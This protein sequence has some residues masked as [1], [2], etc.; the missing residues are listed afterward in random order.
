[1]QAAKAKYKATDLDTPF[2][3]TPESQEPP[4]PKALES[5]RDLSLTQDQE[6]IRL[7][8]PYPMKE[9]CFKANMTI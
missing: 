3:L 5:P 1:M 2:N 7:K 6:A 9:S 4:D 8:S